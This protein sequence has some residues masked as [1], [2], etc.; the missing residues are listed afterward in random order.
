MTE[1]MRSKTPINWVNTESV[2]IYK[3]L[4]FRR[5]LSWRRVSLSINSADREWDYTTTKSLANDK[6]YDNVSKFLEKNQKSSSIF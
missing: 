4:I 2:D 1:S 6:K 5:W 3:Y